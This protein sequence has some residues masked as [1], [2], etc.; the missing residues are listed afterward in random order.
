MEK[1]LIVDD[2]QEAC[3][4]L[5]LMLKKL[6]P[7]T[8][9]ILEADD[10]V[11]AR[12]LLQQH[13]IDLLFLDIQLRSGNGFELLEKGK[14]PFQLIFTTAY[15]Q[16]AVKAFR[17]SAVDYLLKPFGL[18]ELKESIQRTTIDSQSGKGTAMLEQMLESKRL[19]Q[20][21]LPTP[22]GYEQYPLEQILRIQAAVNYS[23]VYLQ[24]R[25]LLVAKTLKAYD[26]L[27]KD[28]GFL[29]IH[30]SHLINAQHVKKLG[31]SKELKLEMKCGEA[32]P[33]S[34]RRYSA[35]KE[36]LKQLL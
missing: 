14:Q 11:P 16:Y 10:V 26:D 2:E 35:V 34:R 6:V 18:E 5:K 8:C 27:L 7:D 22:H 25:K 15:D 12:A 29:R 19:D 3:T 23:E 36:Q 1:I 21:M 30:Q 32:L 31:S 28:S 24:D 9:T 20:I 17:F 4:V 33:V 13:K